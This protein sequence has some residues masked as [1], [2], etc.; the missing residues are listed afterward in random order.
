VKILVVNGPNFATLGRR[1][2]EIYGKQTLADIEKALMHRAG[3]L[4]CQLR[5]FQSNHEGALIDEIESRAQETDA[6]IINPGG[7]SHTSYPLY[8]ALRAFAK[9]VLEVHISNVF[10]REEF[11]HRSVT[12][13]AAVGVITGLGTS[14]YLLALEFL[15]RDSSR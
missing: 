15:A 12:G 7:L 6:I 8:D 1:E 9:P 14:S 11:R 2:V 10:A 3:E 5:F 13:A 4:G